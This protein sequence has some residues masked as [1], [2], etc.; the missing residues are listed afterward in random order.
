MTRVDSTDRR[1]GV[2]SQERVTVRVPDLPS[3]REHTVAVPNERT[4]MTEEVVE[5]V[6]RIDHR[7]LHG[8]FVYRAQ[9]ILF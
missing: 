1:W 8:T 5:P 4:R 7:A 6:I 9:R 3:R 2:A